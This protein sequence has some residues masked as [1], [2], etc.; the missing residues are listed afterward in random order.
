MNPAIAVYFEKLRLL[1]EAFKQEIDSLPAEALDWSPGPEMNSMAVLAVHTAGAAR[2]IIGEV[3]GGDPAH[4]DRESEF[5]VDG[6]DAAVLIAHLDAALA[7]HEQTLAQLELSDLEAARFSPK[8]NQEKSVMWALIHALEHTALHVGHAQM[9]R[10][11]WLT[12]QL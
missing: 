5:A 3:I 9:T 2:Y 4:R 8:H 1:H 7:H 11:L 10:Q 6:R 12:R